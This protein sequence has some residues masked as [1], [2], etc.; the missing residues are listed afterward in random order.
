VPGHNEVEGGAHVSSQGENALS[1]R[2]AGR[3][4]VDNPARYQ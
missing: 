2:A 1:D 3:M 4:H